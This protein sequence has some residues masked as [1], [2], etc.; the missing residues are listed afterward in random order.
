MEPKRVYSNDRKAPRMKK[1]KFSKHVITME[2]YL[3][4][5][6]EFPEYKDITWQEFLDIWNSIAQKVRWEAVHNPLGVKLGSYLGEIKVQFLP[7]KFEASDRAKSEELG[8]KVIH[9]NIID[10]GKVCRI[11][12]ERRWAVKFNKILQFYAFDE[13]RDVHTILKAYMVD[14][15]DKLRIARVTLGGVSVWRQKMYNEYKKGKN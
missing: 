9:L 3:K 14:N 12:W 8:E 15:S 11:K 13:T 10:K 7:Y 1:A 2:L 5:I 6:K 4:F